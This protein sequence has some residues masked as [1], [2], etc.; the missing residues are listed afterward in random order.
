MTN[1]LAVSASSPADFERLG[2]SST[3]I[4]PWEDGARTDGSPDT[5][6]WWYL[7]AHLADAA[8]LVVVFM[9]KDIA[10]PKKALSPIGRE[11]RFVDNAR[12]YRK[13][14]HSVWWPDDVFGG[15][16]MY[17]L[18]DPWVPMRH[19]L[20]KVVGFVRIKYPSATTRC[21]GP[22]RGDDCH[23]RLGL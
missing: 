5:Y 15:S 13:S 6:E 7:D 19:K 10:D 21:L 11:Y 9:N 18:C 20:T 17:S 22:I 12:T 3:S 16:A 4:A 1:K 8:N 14:T 2:L 23:V